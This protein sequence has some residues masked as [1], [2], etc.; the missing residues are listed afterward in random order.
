MNRQDRV[1]DEIGSMLGDAQDALRRAGEETGDAARELRH[2][3]ASN[4]DDA[5]SRL[6]WLEDD[7]RHRAKMATRAT[8]HYLH[9]NPWQGMAG[10]A[11]LGFVAGL[12]MNRR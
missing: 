4:L 7:A 10:A 2:R 1:V 8:D 5:R 9:A 6:N 11:V 12:L 3:I